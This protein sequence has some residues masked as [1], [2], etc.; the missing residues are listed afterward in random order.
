MDRGAIGFLFVGAGLL[1]STSAP[2][3]GV[4][5]I[6]SGALLMII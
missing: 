1:L 5:V 3:F 4:I 6:A 2:L